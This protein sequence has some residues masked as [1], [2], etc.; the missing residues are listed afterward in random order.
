DRQQLLT[1]LCVPNLHFASTSCWWYPCTA[2]TRQAFALWAEG[3]ACDPAGVPLERK[4]FLAG[5]RLPDLHF[6]STDAGQ[7]FEIRAE[8]HA[9]DLVGVAL[10]G[11]RQEFL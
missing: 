7:A 1:R 3:H 8:S 4:E 11:E 9:I 10:E 2:T 6:P 5:L